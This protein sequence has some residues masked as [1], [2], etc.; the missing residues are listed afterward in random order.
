M[1]R[2][3]GLG[4]RRIDLAVG[5]TSEAAFRLGVDCTGLLRD[6]D[7][8]SRDVY[9]PRFFRHAGWR[10]MRVTPAMWMDDRARVLARIA[11]IVGEAAP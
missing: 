11:A 10:V 4:H 2:A 5:R 8:M 3:F 1:E 6:P 7:A 9:G